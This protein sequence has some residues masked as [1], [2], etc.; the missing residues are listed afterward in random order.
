[1]SACISVFPWLFSSLACPPPLQLTEQVDRLTLLKGHDRL[2]PIRGAAHASRPAAPGAPPLLTADI[3]H[4]HGDDL[5]VEGPLD[6]VLNLDLVRVARHLE[7]VLPQLHQPGVLL[8]DQRAT[9]D[10]LII[11]PCTPYCAQSRWMTSTAS[12]VSSK[13]GRASWR[14]RGEASGGAAEECEVR[15]TE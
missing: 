11:H 12:R 7:R 4:V 3:D 2:L 1:M 14:E 9:Q 13:I 8:G 10:V 5:D 6:R 15:S